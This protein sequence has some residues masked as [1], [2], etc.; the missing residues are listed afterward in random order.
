[1]GKG[2]SGSMGSRMSL[3]SSGTSEG[4]GQFPERRNKKTGSCHDAQDDRL[5]RLQDDDGL[6]RARDNG[7]KECTG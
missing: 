4:G 5:G 7:T 6:R 2:D 1:M 3:C